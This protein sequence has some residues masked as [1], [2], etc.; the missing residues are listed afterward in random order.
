VEQRVVAG[1][2]G[3]GGEEIMYQARVGEEGGKGRKEGREGGRKEGRKVGCN[4][5]SENIR[6]PHTEV[7]E[8]CGNCL[9]CVNILRVCPLDIAWIPANLKER[10]ER[11]HRHQGHQRQPSTVCKCNIYNHH[12]K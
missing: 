11:H 2:G 3:G 1:G 6:E 5:R 7:R 8:N 12:M 4:G 9:V 10:N